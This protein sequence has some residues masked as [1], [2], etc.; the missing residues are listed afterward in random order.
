MA[1]CWI[2]RDF[3]SARVNGPGFI[4][5]VRYDS[6]TWSLFEAEGHTRFWARLFWL[7]TKAH[8]QA[9]WEKGTIIE[10]C[11]AYRRVCLARVK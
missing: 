7:I 8:Q 4:K 9:K 10:S 1:C 2:M 5:K 11:S 6:L 3:S